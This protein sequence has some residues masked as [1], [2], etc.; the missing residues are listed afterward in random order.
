LGL[1]DVY[2]KKTGFIDGQHRLSAYHSIGKPEMIWIQLWEYTDLSDMLQKFRDI[3]NNTP[4]EEY[5][6]ENANK[7]IN[8]PGELS[9][10]KE[11]YDILIKHVE[12]KYRHCIRD[13]DTPQWPNFNKNKFR[14]L[15]NH[16]LELKESNQHNIIQT[17]EDFNISI[18]DKMMKGKK[19]EK[20][21][22]SKNQIKPELYI[23]R[24]LIDL[25]NQS[26]ILKQ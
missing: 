9:D 25:W 12:T 2:I 3:N 21:W 20:T 7:L 23:N 16:I 18:R 17:F 1:F 14:Q 4:I 26:I 15:V 8:N 13:S 24:Y 22:V 19:A 10:D 6:R 11:K 5:V